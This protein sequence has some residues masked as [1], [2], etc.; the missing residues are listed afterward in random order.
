MP[1]I[2]VLDLAEAFALDGPGDHDGRLAGG[3][4]G[5]AQRLVDLL[6]VVAVDDDGS[7][8]KGLDP[9]TVDIGFPF[10]FGWAALAKPVDVEDGGEIR[11]L[12]IA[13]LVEALPDR[14]F[15]QLAIA[16]QRPDVIRQLIELATGERHADPDRQPL[17]ERPGR[18][19]NPG[20]HR[21]GVTLK[22]RTEFAEGEQLVITDN[23]NRLE[24]SVEQGRGMALGKD[25]MVIRRCLGVVPVVAEIP[26]DQ[27]RHQVGCRHR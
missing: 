7:A 24:D 17:A 10:V 12:V 8:A 5:L 6:H 27:N 1:A 16:G 21:C 11:E 14:P 9:I 26:G 13:R 4:A 2:L 23:A 15:S 25:Q 3:L 18:H 22:P 19:V 20:Q